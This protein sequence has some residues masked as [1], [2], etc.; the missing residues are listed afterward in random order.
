MQL[1]EIEQAAARLKGVIHDTPVS[2]SKTFSA[3]AGCEV[4]LKCENLQKTGSFKVRGAY[5]KIAGMCRDGQVAA[6]VAASA[7]NH[8]QGVAYAAAAMGSQAT[9]VMPKTTPIAKVT[10]TEG[11]GARVVLAGSCYDEA[12]AEARAIEE[13]EGAVFVHP[14]DDPDVIAGQ[15]TIGLEILQAMPTVDAV[16][17]PAGGGGLVSG[18]AACVKQINPRVQV[19]AVQAEK[20]DAIAR[21]FGKKAVVPTQTSST[22][23]DGIAVRAPG[24]ITHGLIQKYV[25]KVVTVSD[26]EIAEAILL[27]MERTKMVVEPAG[28]ASLAALLGHKCGLEGKRAV[29]LLSGGNIDMGFIHRIVERGLISRGRQMKLSTIMDD[30]PGNLQRFA[31][32]IAQCGANVIMV[33]HDRLNI[34]LS[35]GEAILRVACEVSSRQ[36]GEQLVSSLEAVGY[37]VSVE[38]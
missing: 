38:S 9:I 29:S 23:A 30:V 10:A 25:D 32:A 34:G 35:F 5:N 37:R 15:G 12:Y 3:M 17:V 11:Y 27:L 7:G 13:R 14:F 24:E 20:A 31:S 16:V 22:I 4:Y 33:Q 36:H 2:S 18:V 28:A 8:A 6:M 26:D 1:H 19:I 21:S